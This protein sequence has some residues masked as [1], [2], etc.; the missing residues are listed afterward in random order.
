MNQILNKE[1]IFTW[2]TQFFQVIYNL[3]IST[4]LI[5][6]NRSTDSSIWL[7][8][9]TLSS[10]IFV[11]ELGLT[12]TVQRFTS[13]FNAEANNELRLKKIYDLIFN[14]N[15]LYI[16]ISLILFTII[17]LFGKYI[18]ENLYSINGQNINDDY[19][20]IYFLAKIIVYTNTIGSNAILQGAGYYSISKFYESINFFLKCLILPIILLIN[21]PLEYIL[22]WDLI[23]TIIW[24]FTSKLYIHHLLG[25]NF[26]YTFK[27]K[28][29]RNMINKLLPSSLKWGG[30]QMGGYLINYG[31]SMAVSQLSNPELIASFLLTIK[32]TNFS[33]VIAGTPVISIMPTIFKLFK[34]NKHKAIQ[35]LFFNKI[36]I[37][38]TIYVFISLVLILTSVLFDYYNLN[39]LLSTEFLSLICFMGILEL[40]HG[41]TAQIYMGT[42]HIPFYVP[43]IASG[44]VLIIIYFSTNNL[45]ILTIILSQF[46]TQL[47]CNNWYPSYLLKKTFKLSFI[48]YFKNYFIL[49]N[50]RQN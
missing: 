16:T 29:D 13:Y 41:L 31:S 22:L 2:S 34:L 8:F 18:L 11:V 37:S 7:M 20:F 19:S 21:I 32:V 14:T 48:A 40:N 33:R 12:P 5:S 38:L 24:Y 36:R 42:N 17:S 47:I 30:M 49:K 25:L 1:N 39:Y 50:D 46:T 28:F 26:I 15:S 10:F 9:S 27:V 43:S 45:N 35:Y 6:L 4:L 3:G 44:F 23:I